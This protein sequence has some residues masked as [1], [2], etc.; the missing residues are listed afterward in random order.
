MVRPQLRRLH[1][2]DIIDLQHQAP[3]DPNNFVFSLQAII[4]PRD[5]EGEESF[6]FLVCTASWLG[7]EIKEKKYLFGRF[8]LIVEKYDYAILWSAI[9]QLCDSIHGSDWTAVAEQL[10]RYG[11]WEFQDYVPY[12]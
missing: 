6:D 1:S 7:T 4:G 8:Y 9:Q 11:H 2:P 10:S 5:A 3:S 12:N